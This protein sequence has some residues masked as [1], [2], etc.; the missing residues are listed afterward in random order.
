[1][2]DGKDQAGA[3][4]PAKDATA[5][6]ETATPKGPFRRPF[7]R[8][9]LRP[10]VAAALFGGMCLGAFGGGAGA[11]LLTK[12]ARA[13]RPAITQADWKKL[14][15]RLNAQAAESA[16]LATDLK[17]LRDR[18]AEA[19]AAAEKGRADTTTRLGQIGD[20]LDKLQKLGTET[21]AKMVG[22]GEKLDHTDREQAARV[23]ALGER[24]EK[25][26]SAA[27]A[28]VAAAP[29]PAPAAK[30][31]APEPA[32]TGSLPE[33]PA[34]KPAP[35]TVETWILRDVYDGVAIIENRNQRL[36][37]I[38]P[39]DTVPGVGRVE[40]VERRGKTWVVVTSKGVITPHAW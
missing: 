17:L 34:A 10:P 5:N 4:T 27:P 37:E 16:R 31:A 25:T 28:P 7:P 23:A 21:T 3:A 22:L 26:R 39:G 8:L 30:P 33:R 15:T 24:V 14:A 32:L 11:A 19:A 9:K 2:S 35:A 20:R 38:G 13:E 12:G 36:L 6:P 40:A 29:A 18:A 1:M